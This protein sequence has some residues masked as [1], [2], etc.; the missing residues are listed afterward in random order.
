[1]ALPVLVECRKDMGWST[2]SV[3][4]GK[5][6]PDTRDPELGRLVPNSPGGHLCVASSLRCP[7]QREILM[8]RLSLE[9][10]CFQRQRLKSRRQGRGIQDD[11]SVDNWLIAAYDVSLDSTLAA[12]A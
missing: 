9:P 10:Y 6:A 8:P 1:M 2:V 3:W 7:W 5:P 4:R 12:L 11:E